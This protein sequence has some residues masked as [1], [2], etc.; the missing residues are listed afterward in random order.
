MGSKRRIIRTE[1]GLSLDA[2]GYAGRYLL[3]DQMGAVQA[4]TDTRDAICAFAAVL[5]HIDSQIVALSAY[6]G[7]TGERCNDEISALV[8]AY[9]PYVIDALIPYADDDVKRAIYKHTR[10][11]LVA[12]GAAIG[13][14][15]IDEL[16]Q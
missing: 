12:T 16:I 8:T 3:V 1:D 5:A 4:A 7:S 11:L 6:D 15:L 9:L 10:E 2:T 13:I 14:E